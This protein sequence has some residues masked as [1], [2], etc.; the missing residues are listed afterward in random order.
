VRRRRIH[1]AFDEAA[2]LQVI[3]RLKAEKIEAVA[4]S[5]LW[6]IV[7]AAHELLNGRAARSSS[8]GDTLYA[9]HRINPTVREYRRTSSCGIDAS[10]KPVMSHYLRSLRENLVAR[11]L[12]GQIHAVTSQ[13]GLIELS[14]LADRPILALNS[15]PSMAPVAGR[16]LRSLRMHIQ[17]LSPMPAA[18]RS[19]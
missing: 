7:N 17:R 3:E 18:R 15:G 1:K 6:S 10:L 19:M 5:F 16:T 9:L 2:A 4:V 12:G 11:G 8:S 13:G 14:E